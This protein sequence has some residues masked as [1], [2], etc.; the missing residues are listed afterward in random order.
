MRGTAIIVACTVGLIAAG[1]FYTNRPAPPLPE[2][3][4]PV[5]RFDEVYVG[6]SETGIPFEPERF[7]SGPSEIRI[8]SNGKIA[9][10]NAAT[11]GWLYG[12]LSS[13]KV[14]QILAS[15][16]KANFGHLKIKG[17]ICDF[18]SRDLEVSIIFDENK[19]T[20]SGCDQLIPDELF[21][22]SNEVFQISEEFITTCFMTLA[23][24]GNARAAYE[25]SYK[26]L[27]A[28]HKKNDIEKETN[29]PNVK[30]A[31]FWAFV[32]HLNPENPNKFSSS[33]INGSKFSGL[34]EQNLKFRVTELEKMLDGESLAEVYSLV[35]DWR[36][37]YLNKV[38]TIEG[39]NK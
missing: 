11:N 9:I 31:Y 5:S 34:S 38:P 14:T 20:L 17:R 25:L 6:H 8:K 4:H 15:I 26:F 12:E 27:P 35:E 21:T 19:Y 30:Q 36:K 24:K 1:L 33:R 37:K 13:E 39:N 28:Q 7:F 23:S 22:L 2:I 10:N 3:Q 16:N 29:D 32:A 18:H